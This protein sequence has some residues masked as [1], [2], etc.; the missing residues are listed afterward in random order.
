M[1]D[2][3]REL[4]AAEPLFECVREEEEEVTE[5]VAVLAEPEEQDMDVLDSKVSTQHTQDVERDHL[6]DPEVEWLEPLVGETGEVL[7][8]ETLAHGM[9]HLHGASTDV[10]FTLGPR[11]AISRGV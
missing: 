2:T 3:A 8:V 7:P 6:R 10:E 5:P 4:H 11:P 1:L 9:S